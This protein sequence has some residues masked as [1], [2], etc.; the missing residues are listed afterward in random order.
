MLQAVV[1]DRDAIPADR[2]V[3]VRFGD[4]M[5]DDLATAARVYELAGEEVSDEANAAMR[6]YLAGHRRG[7]LGTVATSADMFG[8]EEVDLRERFAPYVE[9]FLR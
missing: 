7:R 6:D 8:L 9:R 5:A 2:S 3:D 4:F 1:R